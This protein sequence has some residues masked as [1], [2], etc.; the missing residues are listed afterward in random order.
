MSV[1]GVGVVGARGDAFVM[2]AAAIGQDQVLP[3]PGVAD[4]V[5]VVRQARAYAK[6]A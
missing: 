6:R 1:D 3:G 2:D 5:D 4:Q